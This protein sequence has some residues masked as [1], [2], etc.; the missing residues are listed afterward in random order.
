MKPGSGLQQHG[1][2][3][4][5]CCSTIC[6][7]AVDVLF[8]F[9]QLAGGNCV[10]SAHRCPYRALWIM[11]VLVWAHSH[12]MDQRTLFHYSSQETLGGK[13]EE[14]GRFYWIARETLLSWRH[15]IWGEQ[16]SDGVVLLSGHVWRE[17]S[18]LLE[19]CQTQHLSYEVASGRA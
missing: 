19:W 14:W 10:R 5:L 3:N 16:I 8:Y 9:L 2:G 6:C 13:G 18:S 12:T 4:A 7:N 15:G 1:K 11:R 17:C